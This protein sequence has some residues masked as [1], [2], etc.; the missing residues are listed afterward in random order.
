MTPEQLFSIASTLAA[1]G[2]LLLVLLPGRKWVTRAVA[3]FAVPAAL[4]AV[5]VVLIAV[6]WGGSQ[7]GYSTLAAVTQ[8]FANPWVLLAGW[9]HYLCFDTLV[10]C[11]EVEDARDREM[12]HLLV[13]P[14]LLLTVLFGPAGWLL[15]QGVGL[16]YPRK[17]AAA[18][19]SPAL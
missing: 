14:C 10:A 2:W 17:A 12:P 13:V 9:L 15:Y 6:H 18:G 3:G 1:L 19:R 5:Y 11:W 4:A 8:L 16:A 7:G